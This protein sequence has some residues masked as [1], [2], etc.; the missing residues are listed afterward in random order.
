MSSSSR[1]AGS[2][3]G[4]FYARFPDK[5]ALLLALEE[6]FFA[7]M[8]DRVHELADAERWADAP[9]HTIVDALGHE[10]VLETGQPADAA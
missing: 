6:R 5:D 1:R 3:V 9:I 4:G 7:E 2:S 10:L 8:R